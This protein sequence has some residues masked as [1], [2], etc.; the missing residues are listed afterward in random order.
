MPPCVFHQYSRHRAQADRTLDA[1]KRLLSTFSDPDFQAQGLPQVSIIERFS[2]DRQHYR[3]FS[4]EFLA[5]MFSSLRYIKY[6]GY[7]YWPALGRNECWT[8]EAASEGILRAVMDNPRIQTLTVW[9]ALIETFPLDLSQ[10]RLLSYSLISAAL[11]ASY[12]RERV[13]LPNVIDAIDFFAKHIKAPSTGAPKNGPEHPRRWP[14]LN[15][16]ALTNHVIR[17]LSRGR[18]S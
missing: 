6:F 15:H 4:V 17:L 12:R 5:K 18:I 3:S 9:N 13:A 2:V 1:K 8:G 16:L 10:Y 7:M 11:E 14:C